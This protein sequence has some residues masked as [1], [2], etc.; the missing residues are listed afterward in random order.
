ML[1]SGGTWCSV[2]RNPKRNPKERS[3]RDNPP[4]PSR[5]VKPIKSLKAKHMKIYD[6]NPGILKALRKL[7]STES[8]KWSP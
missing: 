7:N 4:S 1:R 6:A 5:S 3:A 8:K 2:C